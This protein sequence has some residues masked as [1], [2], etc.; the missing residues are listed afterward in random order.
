MH[1]KSLGWSWKKIPGTDLCSLGNLPEKLLTKHPLGNSLDSRD[2]QPKRPTT[3][4]IPHSPL[5]RFADHVP[6]VWQWH[7]L[8]YRLPVLKATVAF[9]VIWKLICCFKRSTC[10]ISLSFPPCCKH[11]QDVYDSKQQECWGVSPA[12][13]K[14]GSSYNFTHVELSLLICLSAQA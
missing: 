11:R 7:F 1:R 2:K 5:M 6:D 12:L 4:G 9:S 14:A 13:I 3:V 8:L 10:P